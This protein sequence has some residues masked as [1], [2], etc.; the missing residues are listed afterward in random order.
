MKWDPLYCDTRWNNCLTLGQVMG[1]T[2]AEAQTPILWPPDVKNW[3]TR[4]DPDAG[5]DWRWDEKRMTEDETV[6]WHHQLN[7]HEFEQVPGV[8][9]GQGGLAFCRPGVTKSLTWLSDWT[10]LTIS[11]LGGWIQVIFTF[12]YIYCFMPKQKNTLLWMW[13]VMEVKSNAIK[14]NIA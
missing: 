6:G 11:P 10:E 8:G 7:E 9:D 3:L 2:D 5:K 14:H 13:L 12:Y 1:R 4:K